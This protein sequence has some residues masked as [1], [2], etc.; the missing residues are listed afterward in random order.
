MFEI[1]RDAPVPPSG[2]VKYHFNRMQVGDCMH[3]PMAVA[4]SAKTAAISFG[5]RH[6]VKF[7]TRQD[8]DRGVL[9]IWRI[10]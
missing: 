2:K 6:G 8:L 5:H 4:K 3:V 1:E 9:R 7:T 10:A